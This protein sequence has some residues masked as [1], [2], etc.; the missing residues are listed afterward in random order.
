MWLIETIL[1]AISTYSAVPVPQFSWTEKN[2]RYAIAAFPVVGLLC[3][4]ALMA[5]YGLCVWLQVEPLLFGVVAACLP[6]LVTGGIHMDGF[7]DTVDALSSHQPREKK[8]VILK[9]STCGAFAV[10]F[11][12]VYLLLSVGCYVALYPGR[13]IWVVAPLFILS[14]GCS[15]LCAVTMPNA[16]G[17]GMLCSFTQHVHQRY[18]VV[19]ACGW[20][21]FGAVWALWVS[22]VC[23]ATALVAAGLSVVYYRYK[24]TKEF[25]G[26]TGDTAGFFL[27]L[28]ELCVLV[29]AWI[30]GQLL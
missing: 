19:V 4:A 20:I 29:G 23:G 26:V 7:M 13:G 5:W 17:S 12:G 28:C 9:D 3:A 24:T 11:C 10:M 27:Q 25:G 2:T 21:L 18:A 8:L 1:V 6:L 30:G 22:P 14:R 15:A 16:R